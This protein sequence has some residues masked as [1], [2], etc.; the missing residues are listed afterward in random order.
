MGAPDFI[1]EILSDS[2]AK[3][4]MILKLRKYKAAKVREYWMVDTKRRKV[5]VY[6]FEED[7]QPVIYGVKDKI[8]VGIFGK[9]LLIDFAQIEEELVYIGQ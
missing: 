8:P 4:D 9:E 5:I 1:I 3:K 7:A 6:F 2:T